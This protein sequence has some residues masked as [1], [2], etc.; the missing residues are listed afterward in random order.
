MF[1]LFTINVILDRIEFKFI[2][3]LLF[4]L[5]LCSL[6]FYFCFSDFFYIKKEKPCVKETMILPTMECPAIKNIAV[7]LQLPKRKDSPIVR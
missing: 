3:L 1:R 7:D 6:F 5:P 4:Y 2:I